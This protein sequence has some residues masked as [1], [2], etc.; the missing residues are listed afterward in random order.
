MLLSILHICGRNFQVCSIFGRKPK[1][2]SSHH[3]SPNHF[4]FIFISR[5]GWVKTICRISYG[6]FS[7]YSS[8]YG[9]D[10]C[11]GVE[12][13]EAVWDSWADDSAA[14]RPAAVTAVSSAASPAS[15]AP[16]SAAVPHSLP[17]ALSS[18]V[19]R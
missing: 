17:T 12:S 6:I 19:S 14:V 15:A 9:S 16:V 10:T 1:K 7:W 18:L 2:A 8:G 4:I 13:A 3:C 11:G 5:G